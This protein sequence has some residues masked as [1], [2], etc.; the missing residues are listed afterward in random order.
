[1]LAS[2]VK[3]GELPPLV[4]GSAVL[5]TDAA[6]A[7]ELI[8][9]ARE[10]LG[11]TSKAAPSQRASS[12]MKKLMPSSAA[13]KVNAPLFQSSAMRELTKT[14]TSMQ[15]SKP[16]IERSPNSCRPWRLATSRADCGDRL[17]RLVCAARVV[18]LSV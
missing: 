3:K 13:D 12:G 8:D 5:P 16:R 4:V 14:I 6:T 15:R 7:D 9:V 1:M 10:A 2:L 18:K 17:R 11:K